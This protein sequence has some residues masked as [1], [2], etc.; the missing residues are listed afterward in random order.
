MAIKCGMVRLSARPQR[1]RPRGLL[2][3]GRGGGRR[4]LLSISVV[5]LLRLLRRRS[6]AAVLLRRRTAIPGSSTWDN[7]QSY[8]TLSPSPRPAAGRRLH[9]VQS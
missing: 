2:V 5:A 6:I 4:G 8:V 9:A 3:C 7:Q 1:V